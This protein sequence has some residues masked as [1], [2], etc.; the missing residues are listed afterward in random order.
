VSPSFEEHAHEWLAWSRTPG[1][2]AYWYYRD[3]FFALLPPPRGPVLEIGCGEGRVTRDLTARG[4]AV[5]AIDASATLVQAA[6]EQDPRGRY[7]VA[8]AQA[9]PFAEDSYALVVAYNSLMDVDDMPRAVGEAA[10]VLEPGGTLV[11]CVTHPMPDA[12]GFEDGRLTLTRPYRT[13]E[14]ITLRDE[15]D[16]IAMTFTGRRHSLEHYSR[17]FESAGLAIEA[18]REPGPSADAPAHYAAWR[19]VP[20]FLH[21]RARAGDAGEGPRRGRP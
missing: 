4:Y 8:D 18:I 2:D 1:F 15:R 14:A 13:S 16:G 7:L 3:A 17:A 19:D 9:L 20:M 12:G 6:A 10:R 21:L 11:A 5:T